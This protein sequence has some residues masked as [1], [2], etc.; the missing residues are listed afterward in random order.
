MTVSSDVAVSPPVILTP[1]PLQRV[2]AFALAVLA[3]VQHPEQISEEDL[4]RAAQEMEG[5]LRRTTGLPDS[6]APGGFWLAASYLFWPNSALNLTARSKLSVAERVQ[7]LKEW[8][9]L[10]QPGQTIGVPCALCGRPASAYLGKVDIPLAASTNYRNTTAR[11]HEGMPLCRGC[12]TSFHALPYGCAISGGRAAVLHSW[13]DDF[14]QKTVTRR[15]GRMRRQADVAAGRFGASRPYARQVAALYEVRGYDR[16]FTA[17]VDLIVFSNS[18]KE[19]T[20][21]SHEMDQPLAEWLPRVRYNPR[22]ADGWRWLIRA[23]YSAKVPGLSSLARSLF[24]Q[25]LRIVPTAAAYL[26]RLA[27]E[28]GKPAGETP[29]LA[30]LIFDYATRVLNVNNS[31][32]E[33]IRLLAAKIAGV[34]SQDETE[35]K[36]FAVAARKVGS[37]QQWLRGQ[38]VGHVLYTRQPE[39]FMTD[40]QWLL[41]FDSGND[42]FLNRNLLLIGTLEEVHSLDPKWRSDDPEARKDT[43]DDFEDVDDEEQSR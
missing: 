1:H 6:K 3:R 14:L 16:R 21:D 41:L 42:G 19:Q 18:N 31:D 26:T 7:R 35:F 38:A 22:F 15:V 12:Q 27:G 40:R 34:A 8:R 30:V 36:K 24:D 17:G 2:G 29:A 32:A 37:L 33:Q 9:S 10:P 4:V 5:D 39:P 43:D 13:D 28:L 11:G 20:L 23:H 25:P